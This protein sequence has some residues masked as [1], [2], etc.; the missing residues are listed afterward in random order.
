MSHPC[1]VPTCKRISRALCYC[2]QQN[3]CLQHLNEHNAALVCQLNPLTDEINGLGD[4]L[5]VLNI[6]TM[7]SD[8]HHKLEQW[9]LDCHEK[10]NQFFEQR[11]L[12]LD[13]LVTVKLDTQR[14]KTIEVQSKIA[15][16]LR[17]Q[18][19]TRNDID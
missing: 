4:R 8:C 2:C 7:L 12:E 17:E 13:R 9:R 14:E 5:N 16:L 1:T 15:E 19:V 6:Q 3:L 11:C 18:D 10:I